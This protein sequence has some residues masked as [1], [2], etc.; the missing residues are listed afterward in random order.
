MK[1][2]VKN[3]YVDER[4]GLATINVDYSLSLASAYDVDHPAKVDDIA[5]WTLVTC[6]AKC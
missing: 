3:F 6:I 1:S 2:N 5:K 4:L